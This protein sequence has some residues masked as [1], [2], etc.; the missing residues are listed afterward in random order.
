MNAEDPSPVRLTKLRVGDRGRLHATR[1]L[2]EGTEL[3]EDILQALG[4]GT[5]TSFR[6][7]QEGHPWIL[8]VQRTRIGISPEVAEHLMVIPDRDTP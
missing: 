2:E 7:C 1:Q 4:L 5:D 8:Q 6:V 3:Q